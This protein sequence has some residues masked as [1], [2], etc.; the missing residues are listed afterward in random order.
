MRHLFR[1]TPKPPTPDPLTQVLQFMDALEFIKA[2]IKM[3]R[4][5][6]ATNPDV[7][8]ITLIDLHAMRN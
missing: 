6:L 1:K 5:P 7:E 4:Q 8:H 3:I 2:D